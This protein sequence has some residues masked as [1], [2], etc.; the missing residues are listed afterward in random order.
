MIGFDEADNEEQY[1]ITTLD[2]RAKV[3]QGIGNRSLILILK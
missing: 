3:I 2:M 1:D